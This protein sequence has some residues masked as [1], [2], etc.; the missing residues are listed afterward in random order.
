M[1]PS[2]YMESLSQYMSL[3]TLLT[4]T[5]T[6]F[7][8]AFVTVI[9]FAGK[10]LDKLLLSILVGLYSFVYASTIYSAYLAL[11]TVQRVRESFYLNHSIEAS[12]LLGPSPAEATS[13]AIVLVV[14]YF[15]A[16]LASIV[17]V[18]RFRSIS[19]LDSAN[20]T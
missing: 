11:G 10:N 13:F 1:T 8:F 12:D 16:W 3:A 9:Y 5:S 4:G 15:A 6:T 18:L 19:G 14:S 2:E 7:L 20:G 17:F